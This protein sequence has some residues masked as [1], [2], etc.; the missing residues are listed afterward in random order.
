[1]HSLRSLAMDLLRLQNRLRC[2]ISNSHGDHDVRLAPNHRMPAPD[3]TV[4]PDQ[5]ASSTPASDGVIRKSSS[6]A[7]TRSMGSTTADAASAS[8]A[9]SFPSPLCLGMA[10]D[11]LESVLFLIK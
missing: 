5:H 1:M 6:S 9:S 8:A 2:L 11:V 7:C 10:G 3:G 4:T